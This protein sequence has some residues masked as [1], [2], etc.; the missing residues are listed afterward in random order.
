[1]RITQIY[2]EPLRS[3][4]VKTMKMTRTHFKA[5]A[6]ACAEIIIR[7]NADRSESEAIIDEIVSVCE[8]SNSLFDAE[9]FGA[10]VQDI[11]IKES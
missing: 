2:F 9:R 7:T 6:N 4:P 1:M 10:W 8:Q 3:D 11:L 5:L